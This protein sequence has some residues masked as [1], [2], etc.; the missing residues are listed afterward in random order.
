VPGYPIRKSWDHSS[1][2][3]SPRHI[4]AS[5]VLH[6]LL[7]P[8]H[9]PC[10]LNILT[11]KMLASTVK[12]S[13]HH[14]TST[15]TPTPVA[16]WRQRFAGKVDLALKKHVPRLR[17]WLFLQ[18]P[19]G[20]LRSQPHHDT[21]PHPLT[22]TVL[23]VCGRCRHRTSQCSTNEQPPEVIRFRPALDVFRRQMLLRKEVIQP[24]LP[25]RLPCYDFV[26][27][28][29]PTFDHSIPYGLGHGLRV[30]PTFVT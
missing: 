28:A 8:R 5:H 9:P 27:I 30:L 23:G 10:A 4:A 20:C 26:P 25:V 3:N 15:R 12:F 14:Q 13:N 6:R 24:H 1:V 21:V 7:M 19:T 18:D 29:S 17:V 2:D 22:W 11:T 16:S